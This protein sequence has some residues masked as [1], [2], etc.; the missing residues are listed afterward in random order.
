MV[1]NR[2]P[3]PSS[4]GEINA[5]RICGFSHLTL[6]QNINEDYRFFLSLNFVK[7]SK[8]TNKQ[9]GIRVHRVEKRISALVCLLE[10]QEHAFI[11]S[12]VVHLVC[13]SE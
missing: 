13:T 9:L 8:S 2:L 11:F 4:L 10:Y 7:A 6:F 12:V 5:Q 3:P 1:V